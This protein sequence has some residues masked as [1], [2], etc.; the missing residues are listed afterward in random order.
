LLN[1]FIKVFS[2]PEFGSLLVAGSSLLLIHDNEN[3]D[4]IIVCRSDLLVFC[5][6]FWKFAASS[7]GICSVVPEPLAEFWLN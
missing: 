6:S 7:S 3:I 5:I 4:S 1:K 2:K